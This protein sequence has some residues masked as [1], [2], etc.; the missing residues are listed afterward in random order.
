MR[1]RPQTAQHPWALRAA[2][3]GVLHGQFGFALTPEVLGGHGVAA[4]IAGEAGDP[5]GQERKFDHQVILSAGTR[6]VQGASPATGVLIVAAGESGG[7][8]LPAA[9]NKD[10][11]GL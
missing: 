8:Q 5:A 7:F 10:R 2:P 11:S 9:A 6:G 3:A 4:G 1:G